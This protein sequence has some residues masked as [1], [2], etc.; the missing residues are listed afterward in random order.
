MDNV[1]TGGTQVLIPP[2]AGKRATPRP[3]WHG[4]RY[5]WMRTGALTSGLSAG[6]GAWW[7]PVGWRRVVSQQPGDGHELVVAFAKRMDDLW[8]GGEGLVAVAASVVHEDDRAGTRSA[9]SEV[10]DPLGAGRAKVARV[11]STVQSTISMCRW[12]SSP[13]VVW[14]KDP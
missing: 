5:A 12:P 13:N 8:E 11:V 3:G 1:I 14:S 4:G 7:W 6:W 9:D 2:D 10:A